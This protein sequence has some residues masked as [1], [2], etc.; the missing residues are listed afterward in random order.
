MKKSNQVKQEKKQKKIKLSKV[1]VSFIIV[2]FFLLFLVTGLVYYKQ[3]NYWV[4][5]ITDIIPYPCVLINYTSPISFKEKREDLLAIKHF[6]ENQDFSKIGLRID[7][8]TSI[9]KKKLKIRERQLLDK[10]IEDKSIELLAKKKGIKVTDEDVKQ[11]LDRKL[12]EY[13]SEK[14][15]RKKLKKL[16][17]WTLKD[18]EEKIVKPSLYK[19]YLAKKVDSEIFK[20]YN[21]KAFNKI[22]KAK[23]EID[24]GE[25]FTDVSAK[26]SAKYVAD[27]KGEMGWYKLYQMIPAVANQVVNLT[28]GTPSKIIESELG[29]HIVR[30]KETKGEGKDKLFNMEQ[31]F[32]S[33]PLF[34][35]WLT[36]EMKKMHY[37]ILDKNFYWDEKKIKVEFKDKNLQEFEKSIKDKFPNDPS[38]ML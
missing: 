28:I 21:K 16:Y 8:S 10:L 13:K 15:I 12:K 19:E 36:Q 30:I 11:N 31:I 34:S 38:L 5:R 26:Y 29:Y 23:E 2:L 1:V 22:K 7:F 24:K 27:R 4:I 6:Y 25:N 35:D 18:F 32:V 3:D 14:D 9:G 33:K 37:Q 20:E 17:C